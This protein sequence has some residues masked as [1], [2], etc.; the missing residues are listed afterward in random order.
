MREIKFRA[1]DK[2]QNRY[3]TTGE[4]HQITSESWIYFI[5]HYDI[6]NEYLNIPNRIEMEQFTG[7]KDKNGV[8]DYANNVWEVEYRGKKHRFLRRVTLNWTGYTFDFK[9]LTGRISPVHANV[10]EDGVIIGN[11]HQSPELQEQSHE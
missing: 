8:E 6:E 3:R 11:I 1:W 9:C 4:F 2:E 10:S 7:L 5:H